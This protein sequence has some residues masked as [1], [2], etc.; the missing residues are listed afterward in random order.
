[1]SPRS[2]A[3]GRRPTS[4]RG[5]MRSLR[6]FLVRMRGLFNTEHIERDLA[7]EIEFHLQ[8]RIED[9]I[10]SGMTPAEA[11]R[12]ALIDSGG[13]ESAK[14]A[15]RDRRGLPLFENFLQDVRYALRT[16]R[17]NRGF[18][19]TALLALGLGVGANAAIFGL[20]DAFLLRLLPVRNP[21]ALILIDRGFSYATFEQLRDRNHSFSGMFAYDES[22]VTMTIDGQPE[23]VD[24][25]F[26]SGSYFDVLGVGAIAG[27]T[28]RA[29]DDQPGRQPVAV[30]SYRYW[31]QRFARDASTIGKT[32]FLADTPCIIV[33]VTQPGFFGRSVAGKSA[34]VMLPMSVQRGVA[35]KDHDSFSVMAR[36]QP[37]VSIEQAQA[38]VNGLYRQIRTDASRTPQQVLRELQTKPVQ[39]RPGIRGTSDANGKFATELRILSGVGGVALLIACV[40]IANLLLARAAGRHKEIAVR[41][42][43]GASRGRLIRQLLT[44]SAVLA[45]AGGCLGLLIAKGG[46]GLLLAA[47]SYGRGPI[48]FDLSVDSRLLAFTGTVCMITG[49]LFGL[50]PALAAARVDVG[51]ILKGDE[52]G[53]ESR[54]LH[55]RT[56]SLLVVLQVALSL[57]L[58]IGS[59]LMIRSLRALHDVDFGFE[60]ETVVAAWVFPA[61]A[62]YD[63][64]REMSLYRDLPERLKA[65][66]GVLSASLLRVRMLRGGWYR[67]VWP[68]SAEIVPEQSRKVRCDP[69][70]PA[71]FETMGIRLLRGREFSAADSESAP[72][73]AVISEAMARK[74]FPDQDPIGLHLGFGGPQTSGEIQIVGM[75]RD[76]RHRI[77]EDRPVESVYIPYTQTPPEGLGQMNLMVRT[78]A[79][80]GTVVAAMR[81]ALHSID[82]NLPLVGVQT[83]AEE[84]DDAFGD[85]RSLATLLTVFGAL[86]LMLTSIG[87]YGTMAYAV[88]R[89]TRELGIRMALGAGKDSVRWMVL[90]QALAL[91]LAGVAI[92]IPVAAAA[93]RL[94]ASLLFGLTAS[95]PVTIAGAIVGMVATAALAA[96]IPARRATQV[97]P[98]VALRYE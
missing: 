25:D 75:V 36:L 22:H 71:F 56:T 97:D 69:V 70:G 88:R 68:Q 12:E 27:R 8:M 52:R 64:A 59:G 45:A 76:V 9:N 42:S 90:R 41:L 11:R 24:G 86:T 23:Y 37:G 43:I 14:E 54:P 51:Q 73:V 55:L 35:L 46:Q 72:R 96:W 85:Q 17:K 61:L 62:G 38:D 6:A 19:L 1:M 79:S 65:I 60:R 20:V 57:V 80:P 10:R 7:E 21:Q 87:V 4:R 53:A 40:N 93:T 95:D 98:L 78:A 94:I 2:T 81:H 44:E 48:P 32:I 5:G 66:P 30:I 89:R 74:F 83:Q 58:L 13:L 84:I 34:D 82:R 91:V 26:V 92:G 47:L 63:H 15:C 39:L 49:V 3:S 67:D 50:V 33:G 18:T 29:E 77:P 28:L 16:L 31:D